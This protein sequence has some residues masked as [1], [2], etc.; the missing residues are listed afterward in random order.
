MAYL[1]GRPP[2]SADC[3]P[4]WL[5]LSFVIP[6][7]AADDDLKLKVRTLVKH[8]DADELADRDEAEA[9]LVGLGPA[10]LDVL[11]EPNDR[12]SA[13]A[14]QR[15]GRIVQKLQQAAAEATARA[16]SVTLKPDNLPLTQVLAALEQQTGNKIVDYR[17]RFGHPANDPALRLKFDKTPFWQALDET[18]D[19]AG[20][21]V[22]AHGEDRGIHLI[23]RPDGQ[24]K[25][26]GRAC[27]SG[28]FRF[29]AVR[30]ATERN[31]RYADSQ[32]LTLDVEIAWEPRLKPIS[33]RQ[34]LE[35]IKAV[36]ENGTEIPP[37]N[38][39][40]ALESLASEDDAGVNLALALKLPPRDTKAIASL[41]GKLQA[42]LPGK[43][44]TFAFGDLATAKNVEKRIAGV[45]VVLDGVRRNRDVWQVL[46]RVKFDEAG[47]ALAT[48]RGWVFKNEA[49][50]EAADGKPTAHGGF[51]TTRQTKSEV[52]VT[53]NFDIEAD[54]LPEGL[55]FVYKTP[56]VLIATTFDYELKDIALP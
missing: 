32:S 33:V 47:D 45:V 8:L 56:G 6:A 2:C 34:S 5:V 26:V 30:V 27:Y 10:A 22:Y 15:L 13:E 1:Q 3:S 53:Y 28:P 42:I 31:L 35:D 38:R 40:A 11:P 23:A 29:E 19:A 4:H 12:L 20:L 36:D 55:K 54:K 25:R 46:M 16:T 39:Q 7:R 44:E 51:E 41:K 24:T 14:K 18:L 52:G 9:A 37:G 43:V 49:Y 17:R 48:H 21:G 50:L